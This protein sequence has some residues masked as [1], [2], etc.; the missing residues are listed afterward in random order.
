MNE[1]CQFHVHEE[2]CGEPAEFKLAIS[3]RPGTVEAIQFVCPT[4]IEDA[5]EML[6]DRRWDGLQVTRFR[7][8]VADE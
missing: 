3:K 2:P 7:R 5:V 1:L 8:T 4:A 6:L